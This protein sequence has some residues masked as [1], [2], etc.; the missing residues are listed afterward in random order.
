MEDKQLGSILEETNNFYKHIHV[1]KICENFINTF[2]KCLYDFDKGTKNTYLIIDNPFKYNFDLQ[3]CLKNKQVIINNKKIDVNFIYSS[4]SQK[5]KFQIV[6]PDILL[7]GK[8]Y[9]S[10]SIGMKE[11]IDDKSLAFKFDVYKE[12]LFVAYEFDD[13]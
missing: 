10:V 11:E 2:H 6:R 12:D 7:E 4:K 1:N 13:M 5:D 9:R 3:N 8:N